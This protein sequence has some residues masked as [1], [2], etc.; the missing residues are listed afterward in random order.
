MPEFPKVS[1]GNS[2][3]VPYEVRHTTFLVHDLILRVQFPPFMPH[4]RVVEVLEPDINKRF[5]PFQAEGDVLQVLE[6]LETCRLRA[7]Q[8]DL[9]NASAAGFTP[10]ESEASR[11]LEDDFKFPQKCYSVIL[12]SL[13][14]LEKLAQ[15]GLQG[16]ELKDHVLPSNHSEL[17]NTIDRFLLSYVRRQPPLG[18]VRPSLHALSTPNTDSGS[19]TL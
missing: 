1:E 4:F 19:S 17:S 15:T 6:E 12:S 11:S 14:T 9:D 16:V 13:P 10:T 7:R 3:V 8:N 2:W 5:K 18:L